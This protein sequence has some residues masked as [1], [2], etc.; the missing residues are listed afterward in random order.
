MGMWMWTK[1][2]CLDA[3]HGIESLDLVCPV[4]VCAHGSP[5]PHAPIA[6]PRATFVTHDSIKRPG[7]GSGKMNIPGVCRHGQSERYNEL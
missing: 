1:V 5:E 3:G 2:E 4:K 6:L 7:A